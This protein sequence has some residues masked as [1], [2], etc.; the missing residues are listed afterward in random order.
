[1][2]QPA[3][4][5]DPIRLPLL[6]QPSMSR[7]GLLLQCG[8]PFRNPLVPRVIA[9]EAM[10]YGSGFHEVLAGSLSNGIPPKL[11]L[12]M[13][14]NVA[15]TY[16]LDA[17]ELRA[18]AAGAYE[19]LLEWLDGGNQWHA[20]FLPP[21]GVKHAVIVEQAVAYNVVDGTARL[22]ENVDEHHT[23]RDATDEE[24]PGTADL[25]MNLTR[26]KTRVPIRLRDAVLV[27]D[28]KTGV[29]CDPPRES[30]QLRSLAVGF[31]RLWGAKR[32]IVAILHAPRGGLPAVFADELSDNDL[33]EHARVLAR[34]FERIGDGS[35][36]PGSS[37]DWCPGRSVCPIYGGSL[38]SLATSLDHGGV[39]AEPLAQEA[40][41]S[42]AV[43]NARLD[44]DTPQGLGTVHMV[45]Q[46]IRRVDDD[47]SERCKNKLLANPDFVGVRP[48][49]QLTVL[50]KTE[51]DNLSLA[52]IRRHLPKDAAARVEKVLRDGGC[53][54][55][56]ERIEMRAVPDR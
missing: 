37:C 10:K 5:P 13:L 41:K 35:L 34:S 21:Q 51:R 29:S 11:S 48:D 55:K 6:P 2:A 36:R 52:S 46:M 47:W 26:F 49:G 17:K 12:A 16:D 39:G 22:C 43:P 44:I 9:N 33:N 18:H 3:T 7:A 40:H 32:A 42:I 27:L 25:A 24:H 4:P 8:W 1:M 23:Y 53:V 30:F 45:L 38:A 15:K 20:T 56:L 19:A 28:H 50:I 31:A 14:P 54:E